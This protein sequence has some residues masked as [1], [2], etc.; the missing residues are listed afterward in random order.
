MQIGYQAIFKN[1][2]VEISEKQ[3]QPGGEISGMGFKGRLVTF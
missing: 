2:L 1:T 3:I